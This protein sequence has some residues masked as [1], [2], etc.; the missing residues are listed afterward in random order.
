MDISKLVFLKQMKIVLAALSEFVSR[1]QLELL[2]H[3]AK[4][5]IEWAKE[6]EEGIEIIENSCL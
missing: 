2:D 3:F 5:D 1:N 6:A 4:E